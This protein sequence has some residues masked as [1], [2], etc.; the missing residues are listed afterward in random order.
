MKNKDNSKEIKELY[1]QLHKLYDFQSIINNDHQLR[2]ELKEKSYL[3]KIKLLGN[4]IKIAGK[5]A[6]ASRLYKDLFDITQDWNA[7]YEETNCLIE[8]GRFQEALFSNQ[9]CWELYLETDYV[10]N[11]LRYC[12]LLFQRALCHFYLKKLDQAEHEVQT[13]ILENSKF[14]QYYPLLISIYILNKKYTEAKKVFFKYI[15]PHEKWKSFLFDIYLY[16]VNIGYITEIVNFI[17]M[18]YDIDNQEQ[19]KLK[20]M[21]LKYYSIKNIQVMKDELFDLFGQKNIKHFS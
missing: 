15:E 1:Q 16:M 11:K 17:I 20:N 3:D 8:L 10:D 12:K 14:I 7:L 9:L 18:L 5:F 6:L 21:A 19:E 4:R 13:G 2:I